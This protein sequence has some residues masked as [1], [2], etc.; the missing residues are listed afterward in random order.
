MAA[1]KTRQEELDELTYH[2][3]IRMRELFHRDGT[4]HNVILGYDR[5][6][7]L[8]LSIAQGD[9]GDDIRVE[10]MGERQ[11]VIYVIPPPLRDYEDGIAQLA[12]ENNV[13]TFAMM[14][15]NWIYPDGDEGQAAAKE[16]LRGYGPPP[17]E[18]PNR[19]ESITV[20]ITSPMDGYARLM[21]WQI[22][23]KNRSAPRLK[24]MFDSGLDE[25]AV[26][27]LLSFASSW[28][29]HC[30]PAPDDAA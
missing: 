17:S 8:V 5:N 14:T 11:G 21:G 2:H 27:P 29:E 3:Q 23:R 4:V 12:R 22:K 24:P 20:F 25:G 10:P 18:H 26:E 6:F 1:D 13:S 15:E 7:N 19:R 28:L 9:Y 16:F 30:L